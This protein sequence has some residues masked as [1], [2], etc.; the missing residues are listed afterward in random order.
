MRNFRDW[1]TRLFLTEGNGLH[2]SLVFI[3]HPVQILMSL[4]DILYFNRYYLFDSA[5]PIC[6]FDS[7]IT[8]IRYISFLLAALLSVDLLLGGSLEEKC[9]WFL[10]PPPTPLSLPPTTPITLLW[11]RELLTNSCGEIQSFTMALTSILSGFEWIKGK[12]KQWKAVKR[13]LRVTRATSVLQLTLHHVNW[14][15][16]DREGS[17]EGVCKCEYNLHNSQRVRWGEYA[18]F[19]FF[20]S[21]KEGEIKQPVLLISPVRLQE[22]WICMEISFWEVVLRLGV[23]VCEMR[24]RL[25]TFMHH[26]RRRRGHLD[27]P[28]VLAMKRGGFWRKPCFIDSVA[29]RAGAVRWHPSS[30]GLEAERLRAMRED[31][32]SFTVTEKL[33]K[34]TMIWW[35]IGQ[36]TITHKTKITTGRF[37]KGNRN[38]VF[39]LR[40]IETQIT[41]SSTSL[42]NSFW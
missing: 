40:W 17:C 23:S 2:F 24:L 41:V 33:M 27:T 20:F 37:S 22:V 9:K 18:V 16:G 21:T 7:S 42:L 36:K 10:P 38:S 29:S 15:C 1:L 19:F 11:L 6:L 32:V 13:F 30:C 34:T 35:L 14:I 4:K 5:Q 3:R 26:R 28:H 31:I 39:C 12:V 8:N 25:C